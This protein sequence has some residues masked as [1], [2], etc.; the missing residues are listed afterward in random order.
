MVRNSGTIRNSGNFDFG[1]LNS[2]VTNSLSPSPSPLPPLSQPSICR[3]PAPFPFLLPPKAL[4][5]YTREGLDQTDAAPA[6]RPS[7]D[8]AK[9]ETKHE[10]LAAGAPAAQA[11]RAQQAASNGT[12]TTTTTCST[13]SR[14]VERAQATH[15][16]IDVSD[17]GQGNPL[18][19]LAE[20]EAPLREG[21]LSARSENENSQIDQRFSSLV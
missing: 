19:A 2:Q 5:S 4:P 16:T 13:T 7:I 21:A 8:L 1:N 11:V 6:R 17:G 9:D 20:A 14:V 15:A 12:T 10:T 18:V 3:E